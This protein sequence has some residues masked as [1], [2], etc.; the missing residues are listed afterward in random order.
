MSSN[1]L[2][3]KLVFVAQI[4][5]QAVLYVLLGLSVLSIGVIIERWWYFRRRKDNLDTLSDRLKKAFGKG[6]VSAARKV[7]AGSRS[8][9]AAIVSEALEW[10][11]EGPE[12][13]EQILAKATRLRRKSFEAGLLFLG[14]LGNNAP[15]I[16]LFGTVLGIVTAFRELG[17]NSMGAMGNVM[18]GI[19]EALIATAVGILVALP[20]V[21]YYNVFQKKGSDVE[22]QAAALGNVVIATMRGHGRA[23]PDVADAVADRTGEVAARAAGVEA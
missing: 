12:A 3:S 7:L 14:T 1:V 17:A 10:Y 19:A 4:A 18:S 20:A 13:V 23:A 6:D 21:I 9:E 5:S 22:E 16:G 2:V 15:F 8:V 11:D